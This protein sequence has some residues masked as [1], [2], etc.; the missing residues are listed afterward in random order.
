[1]DDQ[2]PQVS[3]AE[4]AEKIVQS[5]MRHFQRKDLVIDDVQRMSDP[6]PLLH[7]PVST[8]LWRYERAL[9]EAGLPFASQ[10]GKNLF[11]RQEAQDVVALVFDWKS[12]VAPNERS[13]SAYGSSSG[14]ISVSY[15]RSAE[16]S[17]T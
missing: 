16:R 15:A 4:F 9:E 13:R 7:V 1:V 10:A 2:A 8:E 11:K 17:S 6:A 12:D 14:Y 3:G 5:R